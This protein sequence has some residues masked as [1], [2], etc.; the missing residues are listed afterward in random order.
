MLRNMDVEILEAEVNDAG[1]VLEV[2][3]VAYLSDARQY[4]YEIAPLRQTL[5]KQR[6]IRC[7]R[8]SKGHDRNTTG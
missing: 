4:N 8:I 1:S 3:K 6:R 7:A 2:Q 5:E